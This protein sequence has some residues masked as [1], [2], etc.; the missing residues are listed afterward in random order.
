GCGPVGGGGA[1]LGG[2][3]AGAEGDEEVGYR[4]DLAVEVARVEVEAPDGLVDPLEF[5]DGEGRGA[6]GRGQGGAFDLDAGAFQPVLEDLPVVEG[7]CSTVGG[8]VFDG[9]PG[10]GGGVGACFGFGQAGSDGQVG[11]GDDA[12]S[13]VTAGATVGTQLFQMEFCGVEVGLLPEFSAGRVED[14]LVLVRDEAAGQC[15]GALV[16]L[17]APL[18]EQ[19]VQGR[20]AQGEDHQVDGEQYGG[21]SPDF[22]RHGAERSFLSVRQEVFFGNWCR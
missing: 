18:D 16:G 5:G 22:V 8:D 6:K 12:S 10:G 14:V 13:W 21:W 19:D 17:D 4:L 1:A 20:D 11:H 9:D 2:A 15:Q 3:T 7:Q